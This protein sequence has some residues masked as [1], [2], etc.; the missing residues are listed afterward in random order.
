MVRE[1]CEGYLA[2]EEVV[3]LTDLLTIYGKEHL[4]L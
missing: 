3:A 2:I 4:T 1:L